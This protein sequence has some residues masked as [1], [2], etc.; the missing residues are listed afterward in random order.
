MSDRFHLPAFFLPFDKGKLRCYENFDFQFLLTKNYQ[1]MQKLK[2]GAEMFTMEIFYHKL[3][4]NFPFCNLCKLKAALLVQTRRTKVAAEVC[5]AFPS[6]KTIIFHREHLSSFS[7]SN[8]DYNAPARSSFT[9]FNLADL[10][11]WIKFRFKR[12]IYLK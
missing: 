2:C 3:K 5:G 12:L 11:I 8:F 1:K 7:A 10:K 6:E 4:E 9:L